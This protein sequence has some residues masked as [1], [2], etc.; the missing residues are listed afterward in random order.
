MSNN[1]WGDVK[2]A[3][4]AE[5]VRKSETAPPTPPLVF[6]SLVF[7]AL[8]VFAANYFLKLNLLKGRKGFADSVRE[9]ALAFGIL[10]AR[11]EAQAGLK[12]ELK[13]IQAEFN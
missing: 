1:F 10:A 2:A 12:I 5:G 7:R 11:Y 9:S 13:K 4:G 6:L 8:L 3:I